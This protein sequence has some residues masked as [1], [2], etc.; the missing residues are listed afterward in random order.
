MEAGFGPKCSLPAGH[1]HKMQMLQLLVLAVS[2]LTQRRESADSPAF[3]EIQRPSSSA[4]N[5]AQES[6]HGNQELSQV[7]A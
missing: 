1:C 4:Q 2:F 3:V 6:R 7:K 5:D